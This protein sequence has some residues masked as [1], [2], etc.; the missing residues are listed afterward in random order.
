MSD[1]SKR[2]RFNP[3]ALAGFLLFCV[4]LALLV[5]L[6]SRVIDNILALLWASFVL[7]GS[8]VILWRL[9]KDPDQFKRRGMGQLALLPRRWRN[10][11]LGEN[12]NASSD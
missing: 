12:D 1:G 6:H 3:R 11:V 8:I 9:W 5:A 10:W 2:T 7:I 4:A